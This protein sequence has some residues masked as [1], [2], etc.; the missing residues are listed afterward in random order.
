MVLVKVA[1]YFS[2]H[3]QLWIFKMKRMKKI[4]YTAL[5]VAGLFIG[6][7][8]GQEVRQRWMAKMKNKAEE[9]KAVIASADTEVEVSLDEF[10]L[11]AYHS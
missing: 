7:F 10:E 3:R 5:F 8:K 9:K 4:I 2:L 6:I 11:T 1:R